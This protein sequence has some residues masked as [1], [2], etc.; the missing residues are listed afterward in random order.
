MPH[1]IIK[2]YPG[3]TEAQKNKLAAKIT[4]GVVSITECKET[5]V[6]V[7]IEEIAPEDWPDRVYKPDILD[8]TG[9]LYKTPGYNPFE[10]EPEKKDSSDGLMTY[11]RG[12]AESAM[13]EDTTGYFNAMSWLDL[14]LEDNPGSFDAFFETPWH[15]LNDQEKADR[16]MA[17]RR[18]L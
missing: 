10:A 4:E 2:M 9:I 8:G 12:A 11:V 6:S 3:R 5:S 17:I 7:A 18:V 16:A 13:Q 15:E 1:I 14:E